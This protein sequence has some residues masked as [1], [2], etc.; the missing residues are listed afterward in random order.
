M[1]LQDTIQTLTDQEFRDLKAWLVTTETDRRA[2]QPAVEAAQAQIVTELQDAG[3]LEKPEAVT[4]E[5]AT[6]QPATVPVWQDPG[7]DHSRMYH[8]GDV[9]QHNGKLAR[10]THRGLNHWEPGTLAFDGRI[11][12]DITP[13]EP[14]A[15]A[16]EEVD[17]PE[18]ASAPAFKQPTGGHDAY[19]KGDRVTYKGQVYESTIDNN[20]Y[21]PDAYPAGWRKI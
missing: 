3:K 13:Q 12:E 2:A 14:E 19:K 4:A 17:A 8:Y 7:T 10:S 5:Q 9:V 20:A 1:T 15:E 6:E 11:W 18:G 16:P 21:S